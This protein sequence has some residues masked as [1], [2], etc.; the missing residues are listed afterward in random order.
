MKVYSF[1][2]ESRTFVR[3]ETVLLILKNKN[4]MNKKLFLG[5]FLIFF[6]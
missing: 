3:P 4:E 1:V 2:D 5:I 6:E